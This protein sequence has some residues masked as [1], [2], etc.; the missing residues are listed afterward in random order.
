MAY[1][2]IA[3]V[4]P[5]YRDYKNEWLK[6][7]EPGTT[8]PKIMALDSAASVTVAKLQLNAD[9]FL[10]SAGDALVI[11]YLSGAYDLYLFPTAAEADSNTTTNAIRVANNIIGVL[12]DDAIEELLI[13]DLSQAYEPWKTV[14]AMQIDATI[15]PVGKK[16]SW[17]GYYAESDGGSNW[18]IVK[19][20]THTQ[21][22][23]SIFTL[24]DGK[25]VEANLK[26]QRISV[27]KFGAKDDGTESTTAIQTA[28]NFSE[29]RVVYFPRPDV[30]YLM[31]SSLASPAN[32]GEYAFT[33]KGA[34]SGS[35][36]IDFDLS[37][38][39]DTDGFYLSSR[40]ADP[41]NY[42][43]GAAYSGGL[44][45]RNVR[46]SGVTFRNS[47]QIASTAGTRVGSGLH[48]YFTS[49]V[50]V[51]NVICQGWHRGIDA[52]CWASEF[53][54][55][56]QRE[57]DEGF[58]YWTG[59]CVNIS[60]NYTG[61]CVTGYLIGGN[62][63]TTVSD[64]TDTPGTQ[65]PYPPH[66]PQGIKLTACAADATDNYAYYVNDARA[67]TF[68]TCSAEGT[69]WAMFNV[70]K[71]TGNIAII[72]P[73]HTTNYAGFTSSQSF[74][75]AGIGAVSIDLSSFIIDGVYTDAAIRTQATGSA[76]TN[77]VINM[78]NLIDLSTGAGA[79]VYQVNLN[80]NNKM[81]IASTNEVLNIPL[82]HIYY[83]QTSQCSSAITITGT[84]RAGGGSWLAHYSFDLIISHDTR[85]LQ[86]SAVTWAQIYG[87]GGDS[88]NNVQV[89]NYSTD[90]AFIYVTIQMTA[91]SG[92]KA[93]DAGNNRASFLQT[94]ERH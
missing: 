67:V 60:N 35:T 25:Y 9:G 75:N 82:K 61:D 76:K 91:G 40:P 19:T 50:S 32:T 56:R 52:W 66:R 85:K 38:S 2:P 77:S 89:S 23:G 64:N 68:D 31:T 78:D 21:D 59:T 57:C 58:Y 8:T 37:A 7:Y 5:N 22:G 48:L 54:T 92:V 33:L 49:M 45:Q 94:N 26:S 86:T 90:S 6:A 13:N 20:G 88:L 84:A 29:G 62:K 53:S 27:K 47:N 28:V 87:V 81:N 30:K 41:V 79:G 93:I 63:N 42:G 73:A 12:A 17:Q 80:I 4:A 16:V 69:G 55:N 18:G 72:N 14:A 65:N 74:I 10:N 70:D 36:V 34:G 43:N 39:S 24:A 71:V 1:S 15:L 3:L 51:K 11:P 44:I 83:T 46:I